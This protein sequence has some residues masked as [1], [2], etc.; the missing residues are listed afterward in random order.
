MNT[1]RHYRTVFLICLLIIASSMAVFGQETF[2]SPIEDVS[3]IQA[4]RSVQRQS[5]PGQFKLFGLNRDGLEQR[6]FSVVDRTGAPTLVSLPNADGRTEQFELFE[7]SNFDAE[8]QAKFPEIRS[9]SGRGVTDRHATVK[10]SISPQ[11]I[12]ATVFRTGSQFLE[13]EGQTEII[14]P[15]SK[16]RTVYAVFKSARRTG[17]LPWAC[18]APAERALFSQ[19]KQ[20]LG[21]ERTAASISNMGEIR[22]MR[23]AQSVNGEYS[24]YFGATSPAQVELVLAAINAT[25]T[26]SNGVYE[27]DLGLHL[28]L[29]PET[30]RLIFYDPATDPYSGDLA[31][32]NDELAGAIAAQ[33]ITPAMYDIGHMF[34]ASGGGGNA[35]CIG[36]VCSDNHDKGMGITSPADSIPE[37]DNFD[38]DY[39]VHEVGHQL[40]A[41]HTFSYGQIPYPE[42]MGQDKEIGSGITIMGYAGITPVSDVARHSIDIFHET[43]I[44]QIQTN[45]PTRGCPSTGTVPSTGNRAPVVATVSNYTIPI[46]T[47]FKLTGSATD[48]DGDAVTYNWEQNDSAQNTGIT[49]AAASANPAKLIGPN[50]LSFNSSSS[51]TKYFPRLSTI[52]AGEFATKAH[53]GGDPGV[54][55]EALSSVTRDLNFRLTVRDNHPYVPG[56]AIGQTQ[57]TDMKVSVTNLAGPFK[58]TAPDSVNTWE[59][60]TPQTITWLPANTML[61][62]VSA[63]NVNIRLS[64]NGGKT[65]PILLKA[66]TLN[67][68]SEVVVIPRIGTGTAR[69]M[70]EA[71]GN[72]FFDI[73]DANFTILGPTSASVGGRTLD[74]LN[75]KIKGAVITLT[76]PD[77]AER[78]AVTD[79]NGFYTFNDVQLGETYV[80]RA[81]HRQ[82]GFEPESIEYVHVEQNSSQNFTGTRQ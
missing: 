6:L 65:F 15:Y 38:I 27:R 10:L 8:L 64:V 22:T 41:N 25:L 62:P 11:G 43:S 63:T 70:V 40:G 32:W 19:W 31:N 24:N 20:Q 3:R 5:F 76:L 54:L 35:G 66:N 16:D 78:T 13:L 4:N 61:P 9:F 75:R 67:D 53:P 7:A 80:I 59:G 33:D 69:I 37:G 34:G 50:W 2:W 55:I 60:G 30:T 18:R 39:V 58:V 21:N 23:L 57:Y 36:C 51:P 82:Y 47:P 68:G 42:D 77:G 12:Q 17:E 52:L 46:L 72:I 28:N 1:R 79:S 48:P 56:V 74:R 45:L 44:E 71:A 73:S 81:S 26:R 14:E 29:I 49:I